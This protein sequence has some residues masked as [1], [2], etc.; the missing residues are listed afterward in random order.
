MSDHVTRVIVTRLSGTQTRFAIDPVVSK[1]DAT[2]ELRVSGWALHPQLALGMVELTLDDEIVGQTSLVIHRPRAQAAYPEYPG[3]SH[4]GFELAVPN[5]SLG[6][7]FLAVKAGNSR[8]ERIAQL[9][10]YREQEQRLLFMHIAKAAGSSVNQYFSEHFSRRRQLVH[11]ESSD[12]WLANPPQLDGFFFLSGHV[13][14]PALLRRLDSL[15]RYRLVTVVREPL[16]QLASHLAWIRRLAEQ[17]EEKRLRDHPQ[18]VQN[19]ACKL[20]ATDFTDPRSIRATIESLTDRERALVDNCQ[21]RY[22]TRPAGEWVGSGDVEPALRAAEGFHRI[23]FAEDLPAFLA[24]VA[25]DMGWPPPSAEAPRE[26]VTRNFFGLEQPG[27]RVR[28][29]LEPLYRHDSEL[30]DRLRR[31]RAK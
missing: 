28:K 10:L 14:Y 18:Y 5:A 15:D 24:A 13:A 12:R 6:H 9:E 25:R 20:Q 8:V 1:Q 23:G 21:L 4:A 16:F 22:F 11:M 3:A 27:R 29:A 30:Y 31:R 7:Y 2:D 17:G 26:N 19:F